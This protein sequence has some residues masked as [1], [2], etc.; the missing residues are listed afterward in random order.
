VSFWLLHFPNL[1]HAALFSSCYGSSQQ[2]YVYLYAVG[3]SCQLRGLISPLIEK[4]KGTQESSVI[5]TTLF[6][7]K[8]GELRTWGV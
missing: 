1:M 8:V 5:L 2:Y 7:N 6:A 4:I 3:Q